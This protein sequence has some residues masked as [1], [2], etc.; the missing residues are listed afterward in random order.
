MILN[1]ST[2]RSRYPCILMSSSA[3]GLPRGVR[4]GLTEGPY[5]VNT[6][7]PLDPVGT[8]RWTPSH[9]LPRHLQVLSRHSSTCLCVH[10]VDRPSVPTSLCPLRH[11]SLRLCV[12]PVARSRVSVSTPSPVPSSLCPPRHPSPCLRVHPVTC[13]HV[14]VST[15]LPVPVSSCPPRHPSPRLCVHPTTRPLISVSTPPPISTSPCPP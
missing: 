11:P 14:S 1:R 9:H 5:Q 7:E 3:L 8:E 15:S 12:H 13:L 2:P 6:P 4:S 10:P